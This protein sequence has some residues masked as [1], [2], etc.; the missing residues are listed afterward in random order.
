MQLG[1]DL[2]ESPAPPA[3]VWTDCQYGLLARATDLGWAREQVVIV[4][5]D[6]GVS[7]S[8]IAGAPGSPV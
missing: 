3:Q 6:L 8:G 4:D 1:L 2:L 5:E 7:C